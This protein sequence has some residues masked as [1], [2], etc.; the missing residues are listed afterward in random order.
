MGEYYMDRLV[1]L[2]KY[3]V[4]AIVQGIG[5]IL[6]ISSSGHLFVFRKLMGVETN[7]VEI[8]LVL[9]LASLVALFIYYRKVIFS[10]FYVVYRFVFKKDENYIKDYRFVKGM[11]ISLVPTC[12]AGYFLDDYL[13]FFFNY[14]FM[15][16]LFLIINGINLYMIRNKENDKSIEE[17]SFFSFLKIGIGQCF[18]LIPGISRS[19]SALS[20]CYRENLNKED[21]K[22]FTFIMLFPLVLGSIVLNIGDFTFNSNELVL[23]IISFILTFMITMFS[24]NLLN[25]IIKHNKLHYFM[26]YCLILGILIMFIG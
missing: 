11:I 17:L 13:D 4:L 10:F 20:M 19:G 3:I 16:G 9:H 21:S 24:F 2:V 6:P 14:S 12:L 25:K 1:E 26:Y 18:G 23:L 5:E 8:E 22:K 7:G 15:I